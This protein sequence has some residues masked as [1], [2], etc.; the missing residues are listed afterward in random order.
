MDWLGV[1]ALIAACVGGIGL[2]IWP[3]SLNSRVAFMV[4]SVGSWWVALCLLAWRFVSVDL[5]LVE[6]GR[7]TRDELSW[8]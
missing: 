5:R 1:A 8:P 7:Y 6:V 3:R 2:A 4:I